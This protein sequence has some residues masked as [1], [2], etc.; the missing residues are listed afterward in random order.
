MVST[1]K[2]IYLFDKQ[3]NIREQYLLVFVSV[4]FRERRIANKLVSCLYFQ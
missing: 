2:D 3:A 1:D 4:H